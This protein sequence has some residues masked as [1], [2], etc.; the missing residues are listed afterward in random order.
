MKKCELAEVFNCSIEELS[1]IDAEVLWKLVKEHRDPCELLK[2]YVSKAKEDSKYAY[3]VLMLGRF[4]ATT[5]NEMFATVFNVYITL[6]STAE[7][8]E[9]L[10]RLIYN[11]R[12]RVKQITESSVKS[13]E[14]REVM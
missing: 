8:V 6:A 4:E 10:A 7:S 13:Y 9:Q 3:A 14:C 1:K 12:Q 5:A 2:E 11:Y